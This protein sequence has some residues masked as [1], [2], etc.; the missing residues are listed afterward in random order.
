MAILSYKN[1]QGEWQTFDSIGAL[2][3]DIPLKLSHEAQARGRDNLG[4]SHG[5]IG[6]DYQAILGTY[7][8]ELPGRSW[9]AELEKFTDSNAVCIVGCGSSEESRKNALV[10]W[11]DGRVTVGA[12]P[13]G[14]LDAATKQYVDAKFSELEQSIKN[15]I[16]ELLAK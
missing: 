9:D 10:V 4:L 14:L 2:A 5:T 12:D 8:T 6:N 1:A 16:D 11:S 15:Y 3:C 13:S 7:N